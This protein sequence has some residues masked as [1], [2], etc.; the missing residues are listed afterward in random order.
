MIKEKERLLLERWRQ[1]RNYT[2]FISD[3]V[4]D[5]SLW[6][7]QP[8]KITFIMKEANWEYGPVDLCQWLLEEHK[9][10]YWKTWNNVARWSKALLEGGEY[11]RHLSKSDKSVWLSRVSFINLKKEGGGPHADNRLLRKFAAEDAPFIWEQLSL[12]LPDIIICCGWWI[13][14]DILYQNVLPRDAITEWQKTNAGFDY[15]V[16]QLDGKKI[17]VVSFHHPQRIASHDV[18][19]SWYDDMRRIGV[20]LLPEKY[21]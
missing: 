2:S 1:A 14:A 5:E 16:V 13:V 19:K 10:H 11:P 18:F 20:E 21:I 3:G 8:V 9:G 17:P 15:F 7:K 4:F 12:Y 6:E